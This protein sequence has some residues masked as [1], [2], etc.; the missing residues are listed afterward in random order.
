MP[1][2]A[3]ESVREAVEQAIHEGLDVDA[4]GS[5]TAVDEN[6]R[7]YEFRPRK[8]FSVLVS[9]EDT[10]TEQ[11]YTFRVH[12]SLEAVSADADDNGPSGWTSIDTSVGD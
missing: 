8:R 11:L 6:G 7:E 10:G 4:P 3:G 2:P 1:F 5:W 12:V 9:D